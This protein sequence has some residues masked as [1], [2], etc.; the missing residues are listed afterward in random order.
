MKLN[1]PL[2]LSM[3]LHLPLSLSL[4]MKFYVFRGFLSEYMCPLVSQLKLQFS[5]GLK[6]ELKYPLFHTP[7]FNVDVTFFSKL[8]SLL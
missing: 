8:P 1:V 4:W 7:L 2:G 6:V 3:K 5:H